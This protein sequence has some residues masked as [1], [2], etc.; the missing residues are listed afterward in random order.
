MADKVISAKEYKSATR[1]IVTVPSGAEFLIK[2]VTNWDFI[3]SPYLPVGFDIKRFQK[4][5]QAVA[6]DS[7][8]PQELFRNHPKESA[9]LA[10]IYILVGVI[11]P[12]V[13]DKPLEE[14]EEDELSIY[15]ILDDDLNFLINE[16]IE[17]S[18]MGKEATEKVAPFLKQPEPTIVRPPGEKVS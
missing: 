12:R 2:R 1:K 7:Q 14:C 17:F 16:I 15:E 18:G 8:D 4:D 10:R 5:A 3:H 13:V 9:E 6:K 11:S